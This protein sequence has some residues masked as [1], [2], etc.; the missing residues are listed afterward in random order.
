MEVIERHRVFEGDLARVEHD[1]ASTGVKMR[2]SVFTPS[3]DGPHP[4]LIWLSGLTCTD[5]NFP[6]K[7]A[8]Y[9]AAAELGLAIVAPDTSPRGEEVADDPAYDLGHGAGFYVDATRPPWAKHFQM[10]SYVR[11]DLV[12]FVESAFPLRAG[13]RGL[14]GHSMGG[15]GALTLALRH[16]DRFTSV[17]AF[18]PICAPCRCPWGEKAFT[19]Y[20]GDDRSV[21][22]EHDASR[23]VSAGAAAG[24]FDDILIDQGDADPFLADQLKPPA[25]ALACAEAGRRLSLRLRP[26]YDHSYF[27]IASFI[28]EHLR[29]HADRLR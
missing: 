12:D 4:Y 20:L 13:R 27:F 28:D 8:A 15:H 26:G 17:S 6:Q 3:G 5:E 19:A 21:W 9:S 10:E 2:L 11:D 22:E 7:A 29:F 14:A 1:S 23:L 24:R 16:P 25:F 18:A